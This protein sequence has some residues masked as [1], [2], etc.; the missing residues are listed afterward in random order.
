M[1]REKTRV[2]AVFVCPGCD[3]ERFVS[4]KGTGNLAKGISATG[5]CRECGEEF[6]VEPLSWKNK[7][8]ETKQ[9]GRQ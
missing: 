8:Q 2:Q 4:Y 6:T 9:Y 7:P 1:P 5:R 3:E